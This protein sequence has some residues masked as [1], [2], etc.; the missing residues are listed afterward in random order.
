MIPAPGHHAMMTADYVHFSPSEIT[1]DNAALITVF[2]N[3]YLLSDIVP[4]V[5]PTM[6]G[7]ACAKGCSGRPYR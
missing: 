5:M 4:S 3:P 7:G 1:I 6:I 2:E